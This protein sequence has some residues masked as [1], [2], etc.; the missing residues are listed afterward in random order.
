MPFQLLKN[1]IEL[2]TKTLI[3]IILYPSKKRENDLS[4]FPRLLYIYNY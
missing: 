3:V 4:Q 1:D 2:I